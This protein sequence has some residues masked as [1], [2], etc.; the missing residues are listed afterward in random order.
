MSECPARRTF[1]RCGQYLDGLKSCTD[2]ASVPYLLMLYHTDTGINNHLSDSM[3]KDSDS[4]LNRQDI[5]HYT[6]IARL[7]E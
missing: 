1:S 5:E 4:W 3:M 7:D 2:L 6:Y